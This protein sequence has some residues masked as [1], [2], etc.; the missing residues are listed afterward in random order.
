MNSPNSSQ[1]S[2]TRRYHDSYFFYWLD[3]LE[4]FLMSPFSSSHL[5][6]QQGL[7]VPSPK[8]LIAMTTTWPMPLSPLTWT[9]VTGIWAS[10]HGCLSSNSIHSILHAAV[11]EILLFPHFPLGWGSSSPQTHQVLSDLASAHPVAFIHH[12][13]TPTLK[14]SH[15]ELIS[16]TW[17]QCSF[18]LRSG[19]HRILYSPETLFL[20]L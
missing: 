18:F 4:S 8:Y 20:L 6:H 9:M 16:V 2:I 13:S 19:S 5:I 3:T 11:R 12:F 15:L 7:Q 14:L 10:L 1:F 17:I